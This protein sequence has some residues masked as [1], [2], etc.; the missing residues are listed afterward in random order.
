[1]KAA[2][3]TL[4][5]DRVAELIPFVQPAALPPPVARGQ[6]HLSK[7]LKQLRTDLTTATGAEDI[8]PLKIKRL[9]LV[10]IAMLIGILLALAIA[11]PSLEGI[12]WDSLQQEF[13]DA[14]WGWAAL[15]FVL[16]PLVPMAWATALMGCVNKDL[17]FGPTVADAAR[18]H[19]PQ[20]HHAQRHRRDRAPD[21]LPAP[22]GRPGRIRR[23]RDG[24]E[25][26]R[27]R[28]DPDDPVPR[29]RRRSPRPAS[30]RATAAE[31]P[32]S[33]SSRSSPRSIGIVLFIPKIRG[34]VVPAVKRAASDMWAVLRTPKKGMQLIGGDT[35]GNLIYPALLGLC[36]KAFGY[37]LGFAELIVVQVGA[38]MLGNVA[39]VP[40][41]IGVQEA[42]LTAGLTSFGIPANPALATVIV[43]RAIT[44]A[45]PPIF[46]FFTLRWLR[47]KGYA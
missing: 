8:P 9:S 7:T 20:P 17:P 44:F 39:P 45:I 43:F 16:Y 11:I 19:V 34:K 10:N 38:G 36:L 29:P 14:T 28:R 25:H 2:T 42:A 24:A 35:A 26:R 46:G 18:V 6:K 13:E 41:G 37:D 12:D 33:A 47:N 15:A 30:T 5:K 21:R 4:G 22:P 23:E 1:M 32:A 27:R 31:A 3:D 40:G